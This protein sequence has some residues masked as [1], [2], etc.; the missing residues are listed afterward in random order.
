MRDA[1]DG[2]SCRNCFK[3]YRMFYFTCDR[4]LSGRK[5]QFTCLSAAEHAAFQ[6]LG[7]WKDFPRAQ[8]D[9]TLSAAL[10]FEENVSDDMISVSEGITAPTSSIVNPA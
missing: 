6:C 8:A 10:T 2:E 3:F 1:T 4:S 7:E 9:E 5:L